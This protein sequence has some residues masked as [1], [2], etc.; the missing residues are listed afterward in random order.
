MTDRSFV[1]GAAYTIISVAE[2]ALNII[3]ELVQKYSR[4]KKYL[5]QTA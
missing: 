4:I 3:M 2:Y 5:E 1:D